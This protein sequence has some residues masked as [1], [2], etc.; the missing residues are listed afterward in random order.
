[1]RAVIARLFPSLLVSLLAGCAGP[2]DT[3]SSAVREPTPQRIIAVAPSVAEI[4]FEL[5]LDDRV[6]GV[7]D[8]T[9]WPPEAA[10]KPRIGGLFDPRFE[11]I[12]ALA[13]DLAILLPSEERLASELERLGL[14][15]LTVRH[16]TLADIEASIL[17]IAERAGVAPRGR[18]LA[19]ALGRDLAPRSRHRRPEV[20]LLV[21]RQRGRLAELTAVGSGTYLAELVT[22]LGGDNVLADLA[23]P[24]PQVN[25]EA[26]LERQPDLIIELQP[27]ELGAEEAAAL[28]ADWE[29]LPELE[30]VGRGCVQVVSGSHVLLPGP[31]IVLLFQELDE[32]FD[33]C[34]PEA[35]A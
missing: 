13:P 7:G 15:T 33:L 25:L 24:Y 12:V 34:E 35:A 22:R 10:A 5:E 6:V 32:A 17:A 8:Y 14:T 31:R 2:V 30:A 16:E 9:N 3:D 28:V 19:E 21:G 20:L 23:Q 18:R 4:L 11:E 1:L 27:Q 29:E 26:L